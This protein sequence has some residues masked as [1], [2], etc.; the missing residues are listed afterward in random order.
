MDVASTEF[1]EDGVYKYEGKAYSVGRADRVLRGTRR[2]LPARSPSRTRWPKTTGT[3]TSHLTEALGS[4]IQ[5]VGDDLFVTNPVRLQKG[6]DLG[7]ANSILVKVNQIGTL[8]ETLDAVTH[9][10][11]RR[12]HR[13]PVAPLGRDRGHHDRRPGGRGRTAARSR[14]A[15]RPAPSGSPSTTSCCASRKSW[16]TRPSTRVAALSRDTSSRYYRGTASPEICRRIPA[17]A[18]GFASASQKR[19][20]SGQE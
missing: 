17:S 7:A 6:I 15:P 18:R 4:K 3:A 8:T 11:A 12:L 16:A 5:I 20:R 14:P 10:P 9:G 19:R 1:F 2:R 13:D